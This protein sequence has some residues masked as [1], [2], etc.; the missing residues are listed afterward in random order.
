MTTHPARMQMQVEFSWSSPGR[1]CSLVL[2]AYRVCVLTQIA[3][4]GLDVPAR[5]RH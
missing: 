4:T 2:I 1:G 3:A 5:T